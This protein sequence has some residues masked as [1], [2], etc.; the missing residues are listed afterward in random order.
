MQIQQAYSDLK[1]KLQAST[2]NESTFL[3]KIE[4]QIKPISAPLSGLAIQSEQRA[5][6]GTISVKTSTI[7]ELVSTTEAQ[8]NK[9]KTDIRRLGKEW[10]AADSA[11]RA[12]SILEKGLEDAN[13]QII[14][15]SDMSLEVV[16]EIENVSRVPRYSSY[17]WVCHY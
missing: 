12:Y 10:A 16:K 9:L 14:K 5:P 17:K 11:A 13:E 15:I 2:K 8:V 4:P 7:T 1:K 3:N 6:D